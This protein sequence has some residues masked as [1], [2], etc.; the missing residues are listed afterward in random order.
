MQ[1]L[2]PSL[3]VRLGSRRCRTCLPGCLHSDSTGGNMSRCRHLPRNRLKLKNH[4]PCLRHTRVGVLPNPNRSGG[5]TPLNSIARAGRWRAERLETPPRIASRGVS[6]ST[7]APETLSLNISAR[8]DGAGQST[9]CDP[10]AKS[11]GREPI[12]RCKSQGFVQCM[13]LNSDLLVRCCQDAKMPPWQRA[14]L[15]QDSQSLASRARPIIRDDRA[16]IYA[17]GRGVALSFWDE[18]PRDSCHRTPPF[19]MVPRGR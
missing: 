15:R 6:S 10:L 1:A 4:V 18:R 19:R 7:P 12:L 16:S 3:S 13:H 8:L 14:R 11:Q 2:Y 5:R 9:T 17:H